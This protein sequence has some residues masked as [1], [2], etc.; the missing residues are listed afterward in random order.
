MSEVEAADPAKVVGKLFEEGH[1]GIDQ[2]LKEGK[3]WTEE[4][5]LAYAKTIDDNHPM[6]AESVEVRVRARVAAK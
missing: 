3:G 2:A 1:G 4:E 5:L 6:F